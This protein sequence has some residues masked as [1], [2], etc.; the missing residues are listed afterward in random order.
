MRPMR[1]TLPLLL[2]CLVALA[3][4]GKPEPAATPLPTRDG[5]V[6]R[7]QDGLDKAQEKAARRGAQVDQAGR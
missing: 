1:T 4:F 3:S 5:S 7:A 6:G 2:A